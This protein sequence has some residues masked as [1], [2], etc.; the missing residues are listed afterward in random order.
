MRR[1]WLGVSPMS[2]GVSRFAAWV[3]CHIG[4]TCVSLK[5]IRLDRHDYSAIGKDSVPAPLMSAGCEDHG[6]EQRLVIGVVDL[7]HLSNSTDLEALA[8]TLDVRLIRVADASE[9]PM[10]A[11][12]FPG[13]K[14]TVQALQFVKERGIDRVANRV[15]DD[16]GTVMGVCGGFQL[17]GRRILDP[18]LVESA[19]SELPGLGLLDVVTIFEREKTTREVRGVHVETGCRIEGYEIHMGQTVIGRDM[20]HFLEVRTHGETASRKE[21]A[22]SHH[23]RVIGTY[24][25]GVFDAPAFR[26]VFLNQLRERRGWTSLPLVEEPPLDVRLDTLA[27]FVEKHLNVVAIETIIEQG[28]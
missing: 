5:K 28:V 15:L 21:G 13:T 16:G 10:D 2:K 7:P 11:L 6:A 17:L 26:R 3:S 19:E 14:H 4:T 25:H 9:R 24:V 8:R 18:D 23:G 12:I 22:V 27:D 20:S 1:Y